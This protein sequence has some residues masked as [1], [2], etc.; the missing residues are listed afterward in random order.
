MAMR[1][2]RR[3]HTAISRYEIKMVQSMAATSHGSNCRLSTV[4]QFSGMRSSTEAD[5]E[6]SQGRPYFRS[7][8]VCFRTDAERRTP[9]SGACHESAQQLEMWCR[10]GCHL[11]R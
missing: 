7:Q 9:E 5:D 6:G 2:I 8:L 1:G 10:K 4:A 3:K 11:N